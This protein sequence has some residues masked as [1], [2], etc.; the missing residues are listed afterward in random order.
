MKGVL[1]MKT[2]AELKRDAKA[3]K[4]SAILVERFGKTGTDIPEMLRGKRKVIDANSVGIHF[5]M[6]MERKAN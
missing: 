2:L 5:K 1:I 3:G 4:I 6:Q